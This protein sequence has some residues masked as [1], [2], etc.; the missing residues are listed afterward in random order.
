MLRITAGVHRGRRLKVPKVAATRPLVERARE[1]LFNHLRD[2]VA[3]AVVWDVY[4]GSGI[5][6]LEA[7]SRGAAQ[8]LAVELHRRAAAQLMENAELLGFQEQLQCL[9]I[10]AHRLPSMADRFTPPDLLFFD[11]P[12]RDFEQG[13]ASRD[14]AWSLFLDLSRCLA[15]GGCSVVH[16]PKGILEES[17]CHDLPGL[18]RR[19]YSNTSLYWW[20]RKEDMEDSE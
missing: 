6:G 10:D 20:H 19:D 14:K 4:A 12:Y 9:R 17:E 16:T 5:L 15:P 7:L 1:G 3:D 18:E 11:P 2:G 13:G 8:V